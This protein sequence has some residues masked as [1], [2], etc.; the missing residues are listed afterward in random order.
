[1]LLLTLVQAGIVA[2]GAYFTKSG[3]ITFFSKAPIENIEAVNNKVVSVLKPSTGQVEFSV[4]MK[5]FEFKKALMQEH[6]NDNYVESDKYPK[7]VFKG[8]LENGY[9]INPGTNQV[10]QQRV[11]GTLSLHG[12][13]RPLSAI[14][15]ITIKDGV[16]SAAT[17][18]NLLL[19]DY[20]I[21]IPSVVAGNINKSIA[22]TV[23][24]PI[25]QPLAN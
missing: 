21:S 4:L 20:G 11:T 7:A 8:I 15:I 24:V 17:N 2:Q 16:I 10:L 23:S 6:F 12:V 14:A 1:M 19:A 9:A 3:T 25:Y 18:F 13:T 22:V 5:G